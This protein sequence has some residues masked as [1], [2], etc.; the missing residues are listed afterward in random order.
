VDPLSDVLS[1]LK[2]H[3][4]M[5]GGVD[6]GGEWSFQFQPYD[7]ARSFAL[8]SGHCW[9]SMDGVAVPLE[10]GDCVVLTHRQRLRLA[11]RFNVDACRY[12]I[13][14]KIRYCSAA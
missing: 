2:P 10:G 12:K 6:A 11:E 9:L 14:Y 1:L 8:V 7:C 13:R 4:Y 5:S 3:S